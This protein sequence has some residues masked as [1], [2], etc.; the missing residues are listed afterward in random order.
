MEKGDHPCNPSEAHSVTVGASHLPGK[1]ALQPEQEG[2][3][4]EG[5]VVVDTSGILGTRRAAAA[6][7]RGRH[8]G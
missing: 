7:T 2:E 5:K 1:S 3:L 6:G 4:G 8:A